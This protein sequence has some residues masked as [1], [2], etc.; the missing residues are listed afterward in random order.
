M[1][2]PWQNYIV[3]N[4]DYV[5]IHLKFWTK[6]E[7]LGSATYRYSV[8]EQLRSLA[9][10]Q[11]L[12]AWPP[13]PPLLGVFDWEQQKTT[14]HPGPLLQSSDK[15]PLHGAALLMEATQGRFWVVCFIMLLPC[16]TPSQPIA[17]M[18]GVRRGWRR[19]A[20]W[21]RSGWRQRMSRLH[22]PWLWAACSYPSSQF[23]FIWR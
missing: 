7:C 12:P 5:L 17:C 10:S 1:L 13:P 18:V 6:Q 23:K 14:C 16:H 15:A 9:S 3:R 2:L 19:T 21:G 22:N 20:G 4:A 8:Y 11:A